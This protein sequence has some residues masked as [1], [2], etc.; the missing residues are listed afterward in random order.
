VAGRDPPEAVAGLI[1]L[2][3]P[4]GT[5]AEYVG[6]IR[7]VGETAQSL[8]GLPNRHIDDHKGIV[9]VGD[10]RGI[11][12]LRL[13]PPDEAGRLVGKRID[14]LKLRHKSGDLRIIKRSNK[15]RN[16]DL[17]ELVDHDQVR[18][19]PSRRAPEIE[20]VAQVAPWTQKRKR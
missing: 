5:M 15:A 8:D 14:V 6:V 1:H 12:R 13:E 7:F 10:V 11:T 16:I 20:T 9:I 18:T 4:L 2:F 19:T 3:E 17:S